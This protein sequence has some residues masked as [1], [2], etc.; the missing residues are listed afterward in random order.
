M[1]RLQQIVDSIGVLERDRIKA[2]LADLN[3]QVSSLRPE[4]DELAARLQGLHTEVASAHAVLTERDS[5]RAE[6]THLQAER[7]RVAADIKDAGRYRKER[8]DLE[9]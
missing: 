1:K 8:N 5:A 4:W 9:A 6:L 7:E 3:E 2:E